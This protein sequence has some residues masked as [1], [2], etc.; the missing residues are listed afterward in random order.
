MAEKE[1]IKMYN[2]LIDIDAKEIADSDIN[3]SKLENK[4]IL[5]SGATGYVSQYII[6]GVLKRNDM[7]NSNIKVVALCRNKE[8]ADLRFSQYYDRKDFKLLVQSIFEK[9]ELDEEINYIIHTASPAGL[10]TS[11]KDPVET[12]KVNVFGCD[13]LL[14]LAE[15]KKAEFLLFSSVDVYGKVPNGHFV[16]EHL[17][18]LDTTDARNVYAYAKRASENLCACYSKKGVTSKIVRP[19]QIMGGGVSLEDGRIHIDFISQII[20]RHKIVLKGDG[21][22]IR[23]FI[24]ITDAITGILQVMADGEP[25]QAYNICNEDGE[26]SVLDFAETMSGCVKENI[27]IEFDMEARRKDVEVKH[28]I[29]VVTASSEKLKGL[30]WTPKI[31]IKDA[32]RRMLRYYDIETDI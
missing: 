31:S 14:Q 17:G 1:K 25:G 15:Q 10:V 11:N 4:T 21:T 2:S 6:H 23:S 19:S 20:S 26:M 28:A 3:W 5:I 18:E 13:N 9:I 29:S 22:P 12:F 27:P 30:G 8:K 24:Y 16:E 7:Y 32:C